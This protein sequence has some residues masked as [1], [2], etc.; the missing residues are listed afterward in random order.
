[1][2][3]QVDPF[4]SDPT[5]LPDGCSDKTMLATSV[6]IWEIPV[7]FPAV[8]TPDDG[9]FAFLVQPTYGGLDV[10]DD[11]ATAIVKA[12]G[13]WPTD[14][15]IPSAYMDGND[16]G[17]GIDPRISKYY[18]ELTQG[19]LALSVLIGNGFGGNTY[20]LGNAPVVSGTGYG[21]PVKFTT[22]GA[23]ANEL[24]LPPGQYAISYVASKAAG[25]LVAPTVAVVG[26]AS[27]LVQQNDLSP[28]GKLVTVN[29]LFSNLDHGLFAIGS[30]VSPDIANM[31]IS[32]T[33]T[34][35]LPIVS[36]YGV[37][38]QVRPLACSVL[39][40]SMVP[41]L[42]EG[43]MIGCA[44]LPGAV[45]ESEYFTNNPIQSIGQ[46]QSWENL[47]V[48]PNGYSGK[49][50]DGCYAWWTYED[51]DDWQFYSPTK[52]LQN[53]Y[54]TLAFAGQLVPQAVT[55]APPT[56]I[57]AVRVVVTRVFEVLT[58]VRLFDIESCLGSTAE[59]T[60]AMELLALQPRCMMNEEHRSFISRLMA[61][62][63]A[64]VG[65]ARKIFENNKSWLIPLG[66]T[67][68]GLL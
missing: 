41:P 17:N 14:L 33:F 54:P 57:A 27:I 6:D 23:T 18:Q 60:T 12:S 8:G 44:A 22:S 11:Y 42:L 64:A 58:L 61:K 62:A 59:F 53:A 35:A 45:S 50:K 43:G 5:R 49:W 19:S 52:M 40:T 66:S 56:S 34:P 38:S 39:V 24:S 36:N 63:R 4:N 31:N 15:T 68:A 30:T 67:I 1:M 21:L 20:P 26:N 28:D 29:A 3:M 13:G 51:E 7:Y 16:S 48:L 46:L 65:T 2:N 37:T 9:K 55:G 32:T 47:G 25:G 10:V